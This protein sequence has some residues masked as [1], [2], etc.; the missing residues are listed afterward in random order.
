M[1]RD[2]KNKVKE[3]EVTMK[4]P[5]TPSNPVAD[6][7]GDVARLR[8]AERG[9]EA[10]EAL[11]RATMEATADGILVVDSEGKVVRA[12]E[13]F[14]RLW[15]IP[16]RLM[17]EG[18][19]AKLLDHVLDQLEDPGVF[20]AKVEELYDS[21]DEST[22][23]LNFK[24]GRIF[25]RFTKPLM[26]E[27]EKCGRVWSFRDM[28]ESRGA[29]EALKYTLDNWRSTFNVV[30]DSIMVIDRN[31]RIIQANQATA[32]FLEMP[33]PEI[34][35]RSC[36][37]LV[38]R[39]EAPPDY[40]PLRKSLKSRRHEEVEVFVPES[41]TWISVSVSPICDDRG[42][43]NRVVHVLRDITERKTAEDKLKAA[44]EFAESVLNGVTDSISVIDTSSFKIIGVNQAYLKRWNM[45][46]KD[47]IGQECYAITH[48]R[49]EP[50]EA[51]DNPCPL[52]ESIRTGRPAT[53]EHRHHS[54]AGESGCF[55]LTAFPLKNEKGE[56]DRIIH[57]SRDITEQKRVE[58]MKDEFVST[59]SH[60]LRTPLTSIHGAIDLIAR[61]KAGRMTPEAEKLL[62]VAVRN[63]HRLKRLINDLLDVQKIEMGEERFDMK[64]L[65]LAPLVAE[66]LEENRSFGEQFNVEFA[67]EDLLPRAKVRGDDARLKR[68]LDNF[69]SNAAKFSPPDSRVEVSIS[70]NKQA[71]RVAVRDHGQGIPKDFREKIFD[72]FTQADS[73]MT[74]ERGGTG[75]GL[76]IAKMI[77]ERHGG[78]IDFE[79][80]LNKG[81]TFY[82]ELPEWPVNGEER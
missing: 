71:V 20:L 70:R 34:V 24:D 28:T 13:Q 8:A 65:E 18:D 15:R 23:I 60:E 82:F 50:C 19:D 16:E 33:I 61:G 14:A 2:K 74:R 37:E 52:M 41:N 44:K 35:G 40:C 4:R 7:R 47:V 22:D 36:Y 49:S 6:R 51:P 3:R 29:E 53:S 26:V 59:V 64:P 12:N 73:S 77:I 72:K 32:D 27:G 69:L 79:T 78:T 11:L 80:R 45:K 54:P 25:E 76:N 31:N 43:I 62:D 46:E 21:M 30:S 67:F 56:I 57:T 75:L 10:G 17:R 38:H 5:G 48:G 9:Q 42:E 63:S 39:T 81:T 66:S 1:A 55:A 68:V 58:R